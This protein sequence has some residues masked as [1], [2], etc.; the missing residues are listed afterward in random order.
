M[1]SSAT[2]ALADLR[3]R[4]DGQVTVTGDDGWDVARAI[5]NLL[6]DQRPAAVVE[7]ANA[8]DVA[9]T[10]RF[11]A[12]NGLRV[13]AQST[14]HGAGPLALDENTLLLR[15]AGLDELSIDGSARRARTGAGV[16][17]GPVAEAASEHGLAPLSGSSPT[18]GVV[19]YS[20]GGGFGWLARRYGLQANAVT[21]VELVTADGE[22]RRVDADNDPDLFWALRGGGGN[23]GVVTALEFDLFPVPEIYGGVFYFPFERASE[24]MQAWYSWSRDLPEELTTVARVF[25]FPPLPFLPEEIRG[26]SFTVVQSAF[27]GSE[28]EGAEL[29]EPLRALGPDQDTHAV[30]TVS[31]LSHLAMDPEDPVPY[32]SGA[33]MLGDIGSE[34]IDAFLGAAG[35]GSGSQLV[36]CELRRM[37]GAAARP[38][39]DHGA[40]ASLDGEYLMFAVAAVPAP[41][42]EGPLQA[43]ADAVAEAL[44]P[45]KDGSYLN[46]EERPV[47]ATIS[48]DAETFERLTAVRR[49]VDPDGLFVAS[50]PI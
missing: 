44:S 4:L 39:P 45:W 23:F 11:A 49:S 47:D 9:A 37:G 16:R 43:Q 1:L 38:G 26:K 28:P 10:V 20:L 24:V 3:S 34:G 6:I 48:F 31:E 17:F 40:R 5:Y 27:L 2:G 13:A 33:A 50:H 36:S 12:E 19:G 42:L 25:Q 46:F 30:M 29:M 8:A 15:T 14:G 32:R 7:P 18:V 41:E 22:Q 21:A 35:P